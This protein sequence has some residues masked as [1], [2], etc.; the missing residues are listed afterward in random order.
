LW[1]ARHR[2]DINIYFS[3]KEGKAVL[4]KGANWISTL[5]QKFLIT[6]YS[7]PQLGDGMVIIKVVSRYRKTILTFSN[8]YFSVPVETIR[9][10]ERCVEFFI[11]LESQLPTRRFFNT[12]LADQQVII[13][14]SM[15]PFMKR[16]E[17][18]VQL[19]Q[20]LLD[21]L[22]FYSGFE[23]NDHTGLALTTN[24]MTQAHCDRLVSLQ[25]S[26]FLIGYV[27]LLLFAAHLTSS[28]IA[29]RLPTIQRNPS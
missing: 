29:C 9:F 10:A 14:T 4:E 8:S 5:L 27:A 25:V 2:K 21:I 28:F 20:K 15:A 11:D 18:D 17:Q 1:V 26:S 22:T 16:E 24:D 19:L 23:V 6:L 13:L 3:D 7:I 12:L